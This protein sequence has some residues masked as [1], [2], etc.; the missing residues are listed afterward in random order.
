MKV[1]THE[2]MT[3]P[4]FVYTKTLKHVVKKLIFIK[5]NVFLH[6]EV[7]QVITTRSS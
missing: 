7:V 1:V 6:G 3:R 5:E 2:T 4:I